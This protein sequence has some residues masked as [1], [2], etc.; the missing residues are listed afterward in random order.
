M[1]IEEL[2]NKTDEEQYK[3]ILS[4]PMYETKEILDNPKLLEGKVLLFIGNY[5]GLATNRLC[6]RTIEYLSS[7]D[8][9][10]VSDM[11]LF[12]M[13]RTEFWQHFTRWKMENKFRPF[14]EAK[15]FIMEF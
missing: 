5:D 4:C 13:D 6:A 11:R 15:G 12:D 9:W 1:R 8:R 10:K 2:K 7:E 3:M 14:C